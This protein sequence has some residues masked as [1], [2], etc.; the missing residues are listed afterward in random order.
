LI[1]DAS[2]LEQHMAGRLTATA[3]QPGGQAAIQPPREGEDLF[4]YVTD[5]TGEALYP[6]GV[7]ALGQYDVIVGTPALADVQLTAGD[8]KLHYLSFYLPEF[9]SA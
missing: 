9:V 1:G 5:G 7:D 4:L 2:P 8:E 6:E 3:I